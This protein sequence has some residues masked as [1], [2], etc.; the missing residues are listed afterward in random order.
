MLK[1]PSFIGLDASELC[2]RLDGLADAVGCEQSK[3]VR[4]AAHTGAFIMWHPDYIRV[5]WWAGSVHVHAAGK[6]V[7]IGVGSTVV[8]VLWADRS[9]CV[10]GSFC[11]TVVWQMPSLRQGTGARGNAAAG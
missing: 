11:L 10:E 7:Y 3:A 4:L 5:S 6:L 1:Q 2:Q 9:S 8:A